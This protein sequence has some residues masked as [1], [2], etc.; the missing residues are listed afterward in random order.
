MQDVDFCQLVDNVLVPVSEI[1]RITSPNSDNMGSGFVCTSDD[2]CRSIGHVFWSPVLVP[3]GPQIY[4][5]SPE[6]EATSMVPG[7][8]S[9][10]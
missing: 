5:Y 4:P 2:D 8:I 9:E 1:Y 3:G 10:E 6:V 7:D